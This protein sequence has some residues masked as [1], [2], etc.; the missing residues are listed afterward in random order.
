[1]VCLCKF[2]FVISN[3]DF[4]LFTL[5]IYKYENTNQKFKNLNFIYISCLFQKFDLPL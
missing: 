2:E 1:M 5:Q 4:Q 3:D